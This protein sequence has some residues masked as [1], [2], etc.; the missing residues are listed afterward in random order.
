VELKKLHIDATPKTPQIDFD[1]TTGELVLTGRSIPENAAKVY[2]SV[3]QWVNVYKNS[4]KRMTNLKLNLEYFNTS[5]TLWLAKI[6]QSLSK[7]K[8]K[9]CT[10]MIHI[11][12]GI[13]EF[14]N[15]EGDE[16]KDELH[17]IIQLIDYTEISV[18][19][20]LYGT[21]EDGKIVK[22]IMVLI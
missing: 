1:H 21:S 17:P 3:L 16:L 4:P 5:S 9:S 22:D 15:M 18:G 14:E 20:K 6:V 19:I 7:I 10:L 2:E 11:F 13:E 12:I 8:N